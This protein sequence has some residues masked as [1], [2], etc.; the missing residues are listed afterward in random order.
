MQRERTQGEWTRY[1]RS[2]D[3]PVE[4]MHAHFERH[5]Y[6]RHSHETY[7]FGVTDEGAQ[8]FTC[9]GAGYTSAA[10][11]VMAFNPDDPH[12]GHASG[13]TGFTYR[14][15]HIGPGLIRDTLGDAFGR[16]AG[17]PL[18]RDPVVSDPVL[19]RALRQA[20]RALLDGAEPLRWEESLARAVLSAAR[21]TGGVTWS[22]PRLTGSRDVAERA[23]RVLAESYR[24]DIGA[25]E[26][27]A[28]AGGSRFA[29]YRAFLSAYGMAPSDYQRQLRMREARRL[30]AGG[31]TVAETAAEVGFADQ[32][33]LTRW[34]VRC[35]GITPGRYRAA[36]IPAKAKSPTFS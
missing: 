12:D 9:R 33:H 24:T 34:F 7:S 27:A 2:P 10:G 26:L 23:R 13:G 31:R 17:L 28:A 22:P 18:F 36:L 4:A 25:A 16:P 35:F 19:A 11:M 30:L 29:V 20:A 3:H 1:R 6:H 15:I 8:S 21:R 14:M 5:V 32:S